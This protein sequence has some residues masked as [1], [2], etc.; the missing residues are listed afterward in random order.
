MSA[1]ISI[2]MPAFAVEKHLEL[3]K[4]AI[5]GIINQTY[6]NWELLITC[7][8]GNPIT[9][10]SIIDIVGK[11][12]DKRIQVYKS[13][14]QFG[15]GII[16]NMTV[17]Y[18]KGKYLTFHDTDDYSEA[19]RFEKLMSNMDSFGIIASNITVKNLIDG[20]VRGKIYTSSTF[21]TIIKDGKVKPSIHFPSA[22]ISIDLFKEIGGFE[23]YKYSSDSIM[24]IKLA[25]YR[26]LLNMPKIPI[27][28]EALFIWNRHSYSITTL[29]DNAYKL[30]KCISAQRKPLR[31][32]FRN[33]FIAGLIKK[34]DDK[35]K[36]KQELGLINNLVG[37]PAL[38]RIK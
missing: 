13:E 26:D 22:I 32:I 29:G 18:T 27:I 15:P 6:K 20:N 34:G 37:L 1:L 35:K 16:R 24:A 8:G 31:R 2:I 12:K 7:D 19:T 25:Y 5:N 33:R 30:K 14:K 38:I 3:F 10:K 28:Q 17:R 23:K 21:D 9:I 4:Q 11:H 36:V